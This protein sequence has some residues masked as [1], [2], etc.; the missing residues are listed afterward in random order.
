MPIRERDSF[1]GKD[2][3]TTIDIRVQDIAHQALEER[4]YFHDADFGTTILMEVATGEVKSIVNLKKI[5]KDK[6]VEF[7]NFAIGRSDRLYF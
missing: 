7:Y 2:V 3:I 1:P 4:L 6:Y 5:D